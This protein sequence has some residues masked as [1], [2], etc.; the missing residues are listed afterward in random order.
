MAALAAWQLATIYCRIY[1]SSYRR[2]HWVERNMLFTKNC[3]NAKRCFQKRKKKGKE[4]AANLLSSN[5]RSPAVLL[6]PFSRLLRAA[7]VA[8]CLLSELEVSGV[9]LARATAFN[10]NCRCHITAENKDSQFYFHRAF[11]HLNESLFGQ[12]SPADMTRR[13]RRVAKDIQM[14]RGEAGSGVTHSYSTKEFN[15]SDCRANRKRCDVSSYWNF[16]LAPSGRFRS[17]VCR[18][19]RPSGSWLE[20]RPR[21]RV[22]LLD[23]SKTDKVKLK[24]KN[25]ER[26]SFFSQGQQILPP[27]SINAQVF[28]TI[29]VPYSTLQFTLRTRNRFFW[30][31]FIQ[32]VFSIN[33]LQ[34]SHWSVQ[35]VSRRLLISAVFLWLREASA[36]S[37][38]SPGHFFAVACITFALK[39]PTFGLWPI[40]LYFQTNAGPQWSNITFFHI[41]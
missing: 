38:L 31:I 40:P 26:C 19:R 9:R 41:T 1:S 15:I 7:A 25:S 18:C 10:R 30:S 27:G 39:R 28:D 33:P 4:Y 32:F 13:K 3:K 16:D 12:H 8:R 34:L 6:H 35:E 11:I 20:N 14:E 22:K 24:K 29:W 23:V 17:M 37:G 36:L 5:S 2:Q 21:D